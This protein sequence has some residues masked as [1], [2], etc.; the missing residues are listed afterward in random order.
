[1]TT[2]VLSDPTLESL[3]RFEDESLWVVR[4]GV[5]VVDPH[6]GPEDAEGNPQYRV[7]TATLYEIAANCN[8]REAETG[9]VTPLVLG[10]LQKD[11]R[12]KDGQVIQRA[13]EAGQPK[14]VG[15]ARNY[16]V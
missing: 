11:V 9:D 3:K 7:S 5:P 2:A 8:R 12:D 16:H 14:L 10:H 4:R 6:D 15:Y 13:Y 1:M